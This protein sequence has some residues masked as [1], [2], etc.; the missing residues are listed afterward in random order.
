MRLNFFLLSNIKMKNK[1]CSDSEKLIGCGQSGGCGALCLMPLL[2]IGAGKDELSKN[3]LKNIMKKH[4][5]TLPK[6]QKTWD[7][8]K[9]TV[10]KSHRKKLKLFKQHKKQHDYVMMNII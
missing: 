9:P 4:R 5:S 2:L 3:I 6:T 10:K 8:L 7:I 1:C